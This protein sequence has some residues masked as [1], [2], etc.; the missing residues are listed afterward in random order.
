[1]STRLTMFGLLWQRDL[2]GCEIKQLI[3]QHMGC[4]ASIA[5]GSIDFA[6]ARLANVG[7]VWKVSVGK[8][9]NRPPGQADAL[10]RDGQR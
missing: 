9:G 10:D 2:H 5:F 1:M 7:L 4:W 8:A 3:E 6:L